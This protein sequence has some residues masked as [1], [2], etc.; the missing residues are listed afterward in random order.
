MVRTRF[1][2]LVTLLIGLFFGAA[3]PVLAQ[4]G[5][6][7]LTLSTSYPS[8]VVGI[9]ETVTL[10]MDVHS[11][12]AQTVNLSVSNLPKDWTAEFRGGGRVIG[13]VFVS[14][15]TSSK[16]ELRVTTPATVKA[17]TYTF[18]VVARGRGETSEFPVEFT[19]K[20]KAP[21][22]LTFE[23]D[24]PT[25]RGG[26]DA[27]FNF[28]VTLKNEGDDDL[29]V[30]LLA[31]APKE[32]SVTFKA[33][34]KD[35]TNLPTDIKAGSSQKIDI[36]ATPL[37]SLAV[38]NYPLTITAQS[39]TVTATLD[40]TAEVVGQPQLSLTTPD[41][42]LSGD[43]YIN[44]SNQI[45]LVL[46][47][48]G[49][50]PAAGVRLSA[51]APSGWTV[52]LNPETVVEVPANNEVEVTAD[53]KPADNAISGDYVVTFRAQP[54]QSASKSADFRITVKTSTLWGAVGIGLIA[55]AVAIV[56]MAVTRFGRR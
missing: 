11:S 2:L 30:S 41:G 9:G 6:G 25:I 23:T 48:S 20:E 50:A 36:A 56:G 22:R 43:A 53:I 31:D 8:M 46:R 52:T 27:T 5:G 3:M 37:T 33:S 38:G 47:N 13:S 26:S 40:L 19:V 10:N 42:R 32:L 15:N 49:N 18:T 12:T 34:G 24:F 45:K 55:V 28:S 1:A 54:N 7:G 14:G 35:I 17:G 4:D 44:R 39:D 21:A 29:S 51:S 16:V